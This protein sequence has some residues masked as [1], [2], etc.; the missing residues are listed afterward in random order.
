MPS[1]RKI[2]TRVL[3]VA[4]LIAVITTVTGGSLLI[5]RIRVR[6]HVSQ[7]LRRTSPVR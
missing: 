3:L 1:F 4:A 7:E 5:V 2:R 6:Q